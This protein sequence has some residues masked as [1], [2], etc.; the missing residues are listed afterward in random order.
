MKWL[1]GCGPGSVAIGPLPDD[2]S[3]V[4]VDGCG[5]VAESQAL[6]TVEDERVRVD[7]WC[8]SGAEVLLVGPGEID[9]DEWSWRPELDEAGRH[10]VVVSWGLESAVFD[11]HVA[12]AW[13]DSDNELV[14]PLV[15][16]EEFGLPVV[17]VFPEGSVGQEYVAARVVFEG[18]EYE[19]AR[20]K[21]R[22]AASSYYPKV[23]YTVDFDS[24]DQLELSDRGLGDKA[25]IVLISTFDD[26]SYVRQNLA[27][28]LWED[29]AEHFGE[30]RLTPR[31]FHVVVYMNGEYVGLYVAAD[32]VDDEFLEQMGLARD[33]ALYKAVD[34]NANFFG[35]DYY[36][37]PKPTWHSGYELK[38]GDTWAPLDALVEWTASA[39]DEELVSAGDTWMSSAEF[40]DWFLF[41]HFTESGDSGGKNSYLAWDEVTSRMRYVPWDFNHSW[42]QDW[43]TLRVGSDT[44]NDFTWTNRVFEA[45]QKANADVLWA[46]WES[47]VEDGPLRQDALFAEMDRLYADI[48]PSAERDWERWG[49]AYRS[50]SGW[51][52]SRSDWTD[53][54]GERRYL[55]EWIEE[56]CEWAVEEHR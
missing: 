54:A 22:G 17:H 3:E 35:T 27:Y 42:G 52:G 39:S 21:V 31:T 50:Y 28:G 48:D 19:G 26:N 47:L 38:E 49:D 9:D 12:D 43:R 40:M 14:D 5:L 34:H 56:R 55:E 51:S 24:E 32:H 46:R 41:V 10:E 7:A 45:H 18:R 36:G 15:Y 23:G 33:S 16:R 25:H 2:T 44:Y 13:D 37:N 8:S 20:V 30:A 6:Y 4:P 1:L 29:I 11:V 53:Y